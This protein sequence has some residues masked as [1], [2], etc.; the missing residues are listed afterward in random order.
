MRTTLGTILGGLGN[1]IACALFALWLAFNRLM[2]WLFPKMLYATMF[3]TVLVVWSHLRPAP[4]PAPVA[5]PTAPAAAPAPPAGY[6][7]RPGGS[8]VPIPS[9]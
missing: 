1:L 9:G 8:M 2:D 4:K 7:L 6:E 5:S 3:L